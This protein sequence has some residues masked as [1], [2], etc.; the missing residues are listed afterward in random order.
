MYPYK[1]IYIYFVLQ[2]IR[3]FVPGHAAAHQCVQTSTSDLATNAYCETRATKYALDR[4]SLATENL[5]QSPNKH[6]EEHRASVTR[7]TDDLQ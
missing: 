3:L 2:L 7:L 5:P 6:V 1:Y 4:P